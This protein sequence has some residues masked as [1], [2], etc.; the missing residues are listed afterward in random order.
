MRPRGEGT[1]QNKVAQQLHRGK[2]DAIGLLAA[3]E[4]ALAE[5]ATGWVEAIGV[6]TPG[7]GSVSAPVQTDQGIVAAVCLAMPLALVIESPGKDHGDDV[8]KA[9]RR[10]AEALERRNYGTFTT[11]SA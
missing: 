1:G 11:P 9:A 8:V 3:D 7:L 5:L 2:T 10:I 6:R 4:D